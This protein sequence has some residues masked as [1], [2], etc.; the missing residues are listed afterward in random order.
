ML[1][2]VLGPLRVTVG[3]DALAL[4]SPQQQKVLAL[5]LASPNQIVS[6]DRLIDEMWGDVP[7]PSA[8][9]LV[10]DYVWRLRR[11]LDAAEDGLRIDRGG[12]GYAIR[13]D[14]KEV[15]ALQLA[16]AV[17]EADELLGHDP[18]SAEQLLRE[19]TGMW[20]GR[21]FGDLS[22][23][24]PSLQAE[25]VRLEELYLRAVEKR[26]DAAIE[27]GR[28]GDLV[29]EL[30]GLTEQH[31][32]RERF[33]EQLML[34]LYRS[35]RQAEALRAYQTLRKTLGEG[36]G[37]EPGPSG[38]ELEGRILLH[39]PDLLW[40]PLPAAINLPTRL[41]SFVGRTEEIAEIAKLLDISRLVTL[42]GP[43][44]IGKTRLATKSPSGSNP[45]FPTAR[46]GSTLLLSPI[47]TSWSSRPRRHAWRNAQPDT[48][49]I[50]SVPAR[51][52]IGSR[53][54]WSTTASISTPTAA[55]RSSVGAARCRWVRVSRRAESVACVR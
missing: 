55:R 46:G 26:I 40:E 53:C 24:S 25:A 38:K 23:Q 8:R 51:W 35:G 9:H 20:R 5:L 6:T 10:Q 27:L 52:C 22:Y 49:L 33:W 17:Q 29:G 1:F 31:P 19:A 18:A 3:D 32:Y 12:S 54:W 41:T 11:L 13:T 16:A 2:E 28:H 47:P 39:D 50:E 48:P 37:I 21:P 43:G 7:P 4:G 14:P 36:L 44:G 30:E 15:D 42:T 45:R 34:A